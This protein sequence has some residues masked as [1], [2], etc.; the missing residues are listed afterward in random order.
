MPCNDKKEKKLPDSDLRKQRIKAF[1]FKRKKIRISYSYLDLLGRNIDDVE[2]MLISQAFNNV[3]KVPIKDI[4]V[5]T[6]Y[7]VGQV[8][9]VVIQGSSYFNKGDFIPYPGTVPKRCQFS[10]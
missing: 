5:D 3:K 6:P 4:Y 1:I 2:T 10:C 7:S 9:Q 8:E